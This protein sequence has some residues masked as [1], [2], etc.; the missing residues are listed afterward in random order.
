MTAVT[1]PSSTSG[2]RLVFVFA[3]V[4]LATLAYIEMYYIS[5]ALRPVDH[6]SL[7]G[8]NPLSGVSKSSEMTSALNSATGRLFQGEVVRSFDGNARVFAAGVAEDT[9][10]PAFRAEVDASAL[11]CKKW[12][13]GSPFWPP[14]VG[15]QWFPPPRKWTHIIC[16]AASYSYRPPT[17]S[18]TH[19]LTHRHARLSPAPAPPSPPRSRTYC[20]WRRVTRTTLVRL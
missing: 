15:A 9:P 1:A 4:L 11:T 12:R 17:L 18:G 6:H 19:I 3:V 2:R 5:P 13:C 7:E 14:C 16:A 20:G 10:S 8:C